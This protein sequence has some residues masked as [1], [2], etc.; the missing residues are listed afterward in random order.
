MMHD[1][2]IK[3]V[4]EAQAFLKNLNASYSGKGDSSHFVNCPNPFDQRPAAD[5]I[6]YRIIDALSNADENTP[7]VV[8][9]GE[10][11]GVSAHVELQHL[12]ATRL[13]QLGIKFTFNFETPNNT[14]ETY[15]K[16]HMGKS[17]PEYLK[18]H[19]SDYDREGKAILSAQMGFA[20]KP[21]SPVAKNNL[22]A[23]CYKNGIPTQF[24]DAALNPDNLFFLDRE[25]EQNQRA[26]AKYESLVR[27]LHATGF[28]GQAVRNLVIVE[29]ALAHAKRL[30]IQLILQQCGAAHIFG[31]QFE[32]KWPEEALCA[33]FKKAGACVIPVFSAVKNHYYGI[34]MV[35]PNCAEDLKKGVFIGFRDESD[36]RQGDD[37]EEEK[38][39]IYKLREES[40]NETHFNDVAASQEKYKR[41]AE[42]QVDGILIKAK[43][44]M[45]R[46]G[47]L[48][49]S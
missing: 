47:R 29:R 15:A 34:N 24:N 17:I 33:R 5:L 21:S 8:L 27:D 28:D 36:F 45:F 26:T 42:K 18:Y 48:I 46:Y 22:Y 20:Y 31:N 30:G 23:F 4:P 7:V 16:T 19:M 1:A 39:H 3:T 9:L 12:V 44:D 41:L 6:L 43:Q 25:N 11:H 13:Q 10:L 49:V 35:S 14:I 37:P 32:M 38:E 40:G 2:M